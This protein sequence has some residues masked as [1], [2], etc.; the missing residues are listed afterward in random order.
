MQ[1]WYRLRQREKNGRSPDAPFARYLL[2]IVKV[3]HPLGAFPKG[4]CF[5]R[6]DGLVVSALQARTALRGISVRLRRLSS[7]GRLCNPM[8][9]LILPHTAV[10]GVS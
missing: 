5:Q 7:R 10:K 8:F 6:L 2:T 3:K 4:C 1:E 9:H